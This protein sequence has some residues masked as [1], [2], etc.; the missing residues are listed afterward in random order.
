MKIL[1]NES[2]T[3][4]QSVILNV[5]DFISQQKIIKLPSTF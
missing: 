3:Q 1:T 2:Q 5:S 4:F